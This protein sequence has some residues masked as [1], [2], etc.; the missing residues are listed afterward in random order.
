MKRHALFTIGPFAL[1]LL[2]AGFFCGARAEDSERPAVDF[3]QKVDLQPK[4]R[5]LPGAALNVAV[6]SLI[7]PNETFVHYQALLEYLA[8]KI[9]MRIN[10]I[11]R[12]TC[13]EINGLPGS[14]GIDQASICPGPYASDRDRCHF[15]ITNATLRELKRKHPLTIIALSR[16]QFHP[17]LEESLTHHN[18]R[19][20]GKTGGPG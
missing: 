4:T 3:S 6:A 18:L 12:K 19:L 11:Q 17:D 10:R 14:G 2:A 13:T 20:P 7:S 15:E 16:E 5:P 8:A 9:D 1:I